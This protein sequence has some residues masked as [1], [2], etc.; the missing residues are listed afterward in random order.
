[1]CFKRKKEEEEEKNIWKN[2]ITL[3]N[4]ALFSLLYVCVCVSVVHFIFVII[5]FI[6][7]FSC[8][9]VCPRACVYF[10]RYS[11]LFYLISANGFLFHFAFEIRVISLFREKKT[12]K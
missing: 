8:V 6:Y 1:M 11:L 3:H 4:H 7:L 12:A 2:S 5:L 9:C 10:A